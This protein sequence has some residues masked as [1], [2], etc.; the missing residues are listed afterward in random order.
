MRKYANSESSQEISL[1]LWNAGSRY[2]GLGP[3]LNRFF[4]QL[5]HS[6]LLSCRENLLVAVVATAGLSQRT[7]DSPAPPWGVHWGV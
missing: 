1:L 6:T 7:E 3:F 5:G 4:P 2:M